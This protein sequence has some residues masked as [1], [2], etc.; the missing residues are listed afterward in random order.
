MKPLNVSVINSNQLRVNAQISLPGKVYCVAF[1]DFENIDVSLAILKLKAISAASYALFSGNITI[2]LSN[3][4]PLTNYTIYCYT[5]DFTVNIMSM[6]SIISNKVKVTTPCCKRL[7]L[8]GFSGGNNFIIPQTSPIVVSSLPIFSVELDSWPIESVFVN[9][10]IE[11][12][13]C[14]NVTRSPYVKYTSVLPSVFRFFSN[15]SLLKGDFVIRGYQGCYILSAYTFGSRAQYLNTTVNIMIQDTRFYAIPPPEVNK[16]YFGDD[17]LSIFIEYDTPTNIPVFANKTLFKCYNIAKFEGDLD[18]SCKWINSKVL[19]ALLSPKT[20]S[21]IKV[22]DSILMLDKKVKAFCGLGCDPSLL[23]YS[24]AF[25]IKVSAPLNP[26]VP[27]VALSSSNF[28]SSCDNIVLDPT[29][30]SGEAGRPWKAI[31]WIVEGDCENEKCANQM[32]FLV[33]NLTFVLNNQYQYTDNLVILEKTLGLIPGIY[34]ISLKLIN[35]FDQSNL[36]STIIKISTSSVVP[37]VT[38]AGPPII[39]LYRWQS[40][41][42]VAIAS[43]PKCANSSSS[44]NI[45]IEYKWQI[46]NGMAFSNILSKSI[47]PK[48]LKLDPYSL[49]SDTFYTIQVAVRSKLSYGQISKASI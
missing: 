46:F 5:T 8:L 17:G 6:Q 47:D 33:R 10:S 39:S 44:S 27:V 18:S 3:L 14:N 20:N 15:S 31:L 48:M 37:S 2:I 7:S 40:L 25:T 34:K 29:S 28:I 9:L 30:S 42:V 35:V 22:D 49:E 16:A 1:N 36:G 38:I 13:Q 23:S 24:P 11:S 4:S 32:A 12:I 45:D 21:M 19:L 43:L 26:V 41:T